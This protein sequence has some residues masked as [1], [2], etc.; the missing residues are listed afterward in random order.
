MDIRVAQK[1]VS[2]IGYKYK[3]MRTGTEKEVSVFAVV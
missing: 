1:Q 2:I 3:I